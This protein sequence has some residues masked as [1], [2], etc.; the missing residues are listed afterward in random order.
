[1]LPAGAKYRQAANK[2]DK[3][4]RT[5]CLWRCL[6]EPDK[7]LQ[8]VASQVSACKLCQLS[9][10]RK[11]AVPGEGPAAA[12]IMLIGEGPGFYENEQ[13]R[14]FVGAAGQYL[15]E[16]LEKAGVGRKDVFIT[17]VV[18]CRPPGN[19]DPLPEELLACG[20]YLER[21]I[22]AINPAVIVT[23]GRYSMSRFLPNVRISEVH[24]QPAWVRGRLIVPMFHPAAALHQPSLKASVERDFT[25]LPEWIQQARQSDRQIVSRPIAPSQQPVVIREQQASLLDFGQPQDTVD[26][27]VQP[28]QNETNDQPTQLSL[29]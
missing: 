23:L 17:N 12:D 19:R 6:V 4:Y 25:R 10:S 5:F 27:P 20:E 21:Q 9:F 11:K 3:N 18:K 15:N 7:V 24:G 29:F 14:P 1:L 22:E 16:L 8:E 2:N 28:D 13:G 26:Q